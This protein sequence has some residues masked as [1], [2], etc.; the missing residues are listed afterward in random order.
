MSKEVTIVSIVF[1]AFV[2][3][4]VVA[5]RNYLNG[6]DEG[7]KENPLFVYQDLLLL[8]GLPLP[9]VPRFRNGTFKAAVYKEEIIRRLRISNQPESEEISK[10]GLAPEIKF[11]KHKEN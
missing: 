11:K 2:V 6:G 3:M 10:S 7:N 9:Y 1:L 4:I 8:S 5:V